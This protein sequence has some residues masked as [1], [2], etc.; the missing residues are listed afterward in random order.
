M[1]KEAISLTGRISDEVSERFWAKALVSGSACCWDWQGA[2]DADGYG[3]FLLHGK[4]RKA[5]RVALT[6]VKGVIPG[7]ETVDHVCGN[8]AC[9]NP[10]HLES[11]SHAENMRRIGTRKTHCSRGHPFSETAA[12]VSTTGKRYCLTCRK[13]ADAARSWKRR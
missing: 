11:V 6:L 5:H 12:Y 10:V 13:E 2:V 3:R 8:R 9:V 4:N 1:A 7:G